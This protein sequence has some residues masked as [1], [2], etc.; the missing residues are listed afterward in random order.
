MSEHL[1]FVTFT[2]YLTISPQADRE[3]LSECK[4]LVWCP[5]MASEAENTRQML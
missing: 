5:L 2:L 1:S 3:L 4:S